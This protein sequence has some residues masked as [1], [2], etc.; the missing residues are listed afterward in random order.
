MGRTFM[1][2]VVILQRERREAQDG[3][4][5]AQQGMKEVGDGVRIVDSQVA[6]GQM[7]CKIDAARQERREVGPKNL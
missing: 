2:A 5:F 1:A 6:F 7:V 4:A 3:R